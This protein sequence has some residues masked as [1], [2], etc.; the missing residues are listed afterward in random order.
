MA[1]PDRSG[2]AAP[3]WD[4]AAGLVGSGTRESWMRAAEVPSPVGPSNGDENPSYESPDFPSTLDS[5]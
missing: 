3:A 2:R 1:S 4:S 5:R